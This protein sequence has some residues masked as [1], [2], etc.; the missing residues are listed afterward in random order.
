MKNVKWRSISSHRDE[1][2][3]ILKNAKTICVFDTETTGLEPDAKIIQFSAI[4]YAISPEGKFMP[5]SSVDTYI[6]PEMILPDIITE[7][8]GISQETVNNAQTETEEV[9]EIMNILNTSDVWAGQNVKFDLL[10][11]QNMCKRTNYP[12]IEQPSIDTLKMARHLISLEDIEPVAKKLGFKR[13][14]HKLATITTY[15]FPDYKAQYHNSM[16]DVGATAKCLEKFIDMYKHLEY[17]KEPTEIAMPKYAYFWI[18]SNKQSDQRIR[19]CLPDDNKTAIYYDAMEHYWTCFSNK[20]DKERFDNLDKAFIEKCVINRYGAK[21]GV[22]TM[23]DLA[24]EMRKA[25]ME[26]QKNPNY[27]PY[28][29]TKP[30]PQAPAPA[31]QPQQEDKTDD[32]DLW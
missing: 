5:I 17:E 3:N 27:K 25:Y 4:K 10:K 2:L 30:K 12:Y 8:T 7:L 29:Q 9:N 21:Y 16:E 26:K 1:V 13:G 6:N 18:N 24:R 23:E 32:I 22:D 19:V 14:N 11:V 28:Y 20:A 15:L 31:P